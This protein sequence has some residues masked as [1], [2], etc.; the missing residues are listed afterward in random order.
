MHHYY[1]YHHPLKILPLITP[2]FYFTLPVLCISPSFL[3]HISI[4]SPRLLQGLILLE[5]HTTL[6]STL[7]SY[8]IEDPAERRNTAAAIRGLAE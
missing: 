3:L 7:T 6:Q 2:Y 4:L 1:Y 8:F 5:L